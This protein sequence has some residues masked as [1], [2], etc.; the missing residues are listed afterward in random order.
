MS[1]L[2]DDISNHDLHQ[3][4]RG[5]WFKVTRRKYPV[6]FDMAEDGRVHYITVEG[7]HG[8]APVRSV[9]LWWPRTGAINIPG[10]GALYVQR[11]AARQWRRSY[12][13]RDITVTVPR[14]T[15][16][17]MRY[18]VL[19][20]QNGNSAPLVQALDEPV[21]YPMREAI[22]MLE[23]V[24]TVAISRNVML[25]GVSFSEIAVY[26][27]QHMVGTV[28]QDGTYVPEGDPRLV[29]RTTRAIGGAK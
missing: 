21:Y 7:E 4:L 24:P 23:D 28:E 1:R 15:W 16:T 3:W 10:I 8:E 18:P 27:G 19:T 9:S 6:F 5:T 26:Y 2:P 17:S 11:H 13:A 25:L 20:A 14:Q 12:S 29:A 22:G